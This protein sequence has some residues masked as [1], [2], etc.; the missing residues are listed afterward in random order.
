MD[1]VH[2]DSNILTDP[3]ASAACPKCGAMLGVKGLPPF[4]VVQCPTCQFEFQVPAR[5]GT[6]M[7]LQ[8]LGAGG[9]GGVYRARDEG[10]NREVAIKVMLKSLGDDPQ[11]VETFQ[12]EAQAA[13]RL[14]H[15]HIAQIYSFGQEKGQPYIAMELVSGGSLD[16][17]MAEQGPLDPT[18]VIHV[19]AQI[20][21]GLS[22]A[23]DA[24]MV[25][26]DVKPE[27]ILF[28]TDKN[29]KLV[30]FG[31]SAMQSGPGNEVWGTPYYIAPEKV[32]RQKS[33][34]R[35]DIYSLGGTLYH[36]IT[37]VPP[38]EG[39]DATAV[40][41]ARFEGPPKPMSEIRDG[42]P[43]EVEAI[44]AR[45]LEVEPQTRFPTYGS[46][47]GD[48]K[49]YLS[50]AGPVKMEKSSK[51]IVLKGKRGVT[52]KVS[53]T[54]MLA[55]TGSMTGNVDEVP[56]DMTPVEAIEEVQE[57]EEEAG[58]RGCR[59]MG[60]IIGGVVALVVV[61]GLI[62]FGVMKHSE[63]KKA[64]AEQAQLVATQDK[65]RTSIATAVANAKVL[66][67][68]MQG[69]VPEA[70]GYPKEAADEVVKAL[71]EEARA[72]MVP[73]EPD[74][75]AIA[76][77][78]DGGQAAVPADAIPLDPAQLA[79][80]TK[81][82]PPEAAKMLEG[83]DKL[84][85][86]QVMAKLD[87]ITKA[88]PADQMASLTNK[89][90]TLMETMAEGMAK[91]IAEGMA[92]M[93]TNAPVQAAQPPAQPAAAETAQ[94][95]AHPVIAI[96]RGMY[97]DAY[98]IKSAAALAERK[99][100]EIEQKA[101]EAEQFTQVTKQDTEAIA[102]LNNELVRYINSL[103][104]ESAFTEAPR[105]VSQLRRT[106]ESVKTEVA[107]L[108]EIKRREAIEA[109][110][111]KQAEEEAEKKRQEK[112]AYEKKVAEERARVVEAEEASVEELRQLKFREVFRA[113][114][115]LK[116]NLETPEAQD[117][118]SVAIDR[119]TRIKDF[120]EYLVSAVPGFKSARGWSV[121]SA[122]ARSLT[123]GGR[124]IP[125]VDVYKERLDIVGELINEL[126]ANPENTKKLSLRE[127]TRVM[128]NAAL[129][130]NFFY[131]EFPSAKERA[132]TLA[133]EAARLFDI[134]ADIIK[135]L[136]P[137]FFE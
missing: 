107:S 80:L 64:N 57:T 14:N 1:D 17:M 106:L 84:P 85:P 133:T 117:T 46:L 86:D 74:D 52:G 25:H 130:M 127:R 93:L 21:E 70:M 55:A 100:Q 31:L 16:K 23:A 19:G 132:K 15:R 71:G 91:G 111:Q 94:D 83:L 3:V 96:V 108:I 125:W 20:A 42:I 28:D 66:V 79:E 121:D 136:L 11:F 97:L 43:K 88:L 115:E 4:S 39:V 129:C 38:F 6:F 89:L 41:K 26:G 134:D 12:R 87:E 112:E 120:H 128:T 116:E 58:K 135:G 36:A 29:A 98:S 123:V 33:D 47:L 61:L 34:Y 68:R 119:V 122:D 103:G 72:L 92:A 56:A 104:N 69:F 62:V 60:L 90:A 24:G 40:V 65:A 131:K 5:F 45:M 81:L 137:E 102:N 113:L 10:L 9:M 76:V 2:N 30:D 7:L 105:K 35:S 82:L 118:A 101:K 73:P 18:V 109:E 67:E 99:L 114:R 59:M 8:L 27:N 78:A 22:M 95:D 54:G 110:K 51:R 44:I 77:A 124:K 49:R 13:A 53:A 50:K 75:S 37:G 48:M 126:A 63:R 32:R